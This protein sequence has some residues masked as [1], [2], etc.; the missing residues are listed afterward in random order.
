MILL[1]PIIAMGLMATAVYKS[2]NQAHE[3]QRRTMSSVYQPPS[4]CEVVLGALEIE[5]TDPELLKQSK[6]LGCRRN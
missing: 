1:I 3:I 4:E 2:M 5:P 6:E